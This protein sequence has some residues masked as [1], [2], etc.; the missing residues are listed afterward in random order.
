MSFRAIVLSSRAPAEWRAFPSRMSTLVLPH[1]GPI[2]WRFY[3]PTAEQPEIFH[4]VLVLRHLILDD[5]SKREVYAPPEMSARAAAQL[6]AE[7]ENR[8]ESIAPAR[9]EELQ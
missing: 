8:P 3:E 6:V 4:E 5:E 2:D 9:F 1:I 7:L